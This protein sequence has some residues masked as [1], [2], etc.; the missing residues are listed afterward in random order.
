MNISFRAV[1]MLAHVRASRVYA[2]LLTAIRPVR[3]SL[4]VGSE[5]RPCSGRYPGIVTEEV[6]LHDPPARE[7]R[8][9]IPH[10][11]VTGI[12]PDESSRPRRQ[13]HASTEIDREHR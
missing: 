4:A 11:P 5:S 8:T 2:P 10:Q 1:R 9:G 13:L 6:V 3:A 12:D 7:R